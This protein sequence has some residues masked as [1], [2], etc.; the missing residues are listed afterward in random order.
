MKLQPGEFYAASM[1]KLRRIPFDC[2]QEIIDLANRMAVAHSTLMDSEGNFHE[3]AKERIDFF[4]ECRLLILKLI[5][6][7]TI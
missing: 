1:D 4:C 2:E 5:F 7:Q 3:N 6:M